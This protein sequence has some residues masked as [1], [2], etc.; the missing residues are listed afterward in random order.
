MK[1]KVY[2][3]QNGAIPP[4]RIKEEFERRGGT[5]CIQCVTQGVYYYISDDGFV[6]GCLCGEGFKEDGYTQLAYHQDGDCFYEACQ[7]KER[8]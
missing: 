7:S 4:S 3:I 1:T 2:I 6:N 5:C 8:R